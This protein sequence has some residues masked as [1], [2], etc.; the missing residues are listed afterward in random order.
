MKTV[1]LNRKL[2]LEAPVRSSDGAGGYVETWE[3]LGTLWGEV[4]PRAG[5]MTSDSDAGALSVAAFQVTV[6]GAPAGHPARPLA[7]HRFRMGPRV[8]RI[9][10][11]TEDEP[12]IRYLLCHCTEEVAS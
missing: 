10:S 4:R 1:A 12:N 2:V 9:A 5:R 7:G 6:R 3:Q 11:V 8:F